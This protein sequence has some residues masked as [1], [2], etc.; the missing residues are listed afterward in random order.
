MRCDICGVEHKESIE[1]TYL[2]L[3]V[4]GSEGLFVCP[5]CRLLI[6]DYVMGLKSLTANEKRIRGVTGFSSDSSN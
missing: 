6:T 3:Y 4:T 2:S 1:L 5:P